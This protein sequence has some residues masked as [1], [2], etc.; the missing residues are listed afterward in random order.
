M[1]QVSEIATFIVVVMALF[2][3][4]G[5]AVLLTLTRSISGGKRTGIATGLGIAAGD[6]LHTTFAAV[7]LSALLVTSTWAFEIVRYL[8]VAYLIYLGLR[9][10]LEKPGELEQSASIPPVRAFKEAI[11]AELLNPKTS[12]FFLAFL[13][14]FVQVERG[15]P[16]LQLTILGGIFVAMSAAYTSLLALGAS[17]VSAW[18]RNHPAFMRWQGKLVGA[19]YICLGVRLVFQQR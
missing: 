6:L 8:G 12:L 2:L 13:P 10:L 17:G 5:P 16:A 4:P 14:Q 7:G 15:S 18:L 1:F 11:F 19:V 9:S 3:V